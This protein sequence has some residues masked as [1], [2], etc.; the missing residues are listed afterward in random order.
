MEIHIK[1]RLQMIA[2]LLEVWGFGSEILWEYGKTMWKRMLYSY[3][4]LTIGSRIDLTVCDH[5]E[6][7]VN[8]RYL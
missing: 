1:A 6:V 4:R 8:R 2:A 5:F 3:Q 7:G